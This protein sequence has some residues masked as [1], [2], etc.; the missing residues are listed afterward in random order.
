MCRRTWARRWDGCRTKQ[1]GRAWLLMSR[2][3]DVRVVDLL[4]VGLPAFLSAYLLSPVR[5][6]QPCDLAGATPGP[7]LGCPDSGSASSRTRLEGAGRCGSPGGML[8]L[9]RLGLLS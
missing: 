1:C 9:G 3:S 8:A 7:G 4:A 6:L 5:A 2:G